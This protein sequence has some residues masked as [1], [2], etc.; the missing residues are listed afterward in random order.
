MECYSGG[1][2]LTLAGEMNVLLSR[3]D[4]RSWLNELAVQKH[5][6]I[7][8]TKYFFWEY[9]MAKTDILQYTY[10]CLNV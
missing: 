8:T 5:D 10:K 1:R 9:H 4:K 3:N 7:V 6:L 2:T